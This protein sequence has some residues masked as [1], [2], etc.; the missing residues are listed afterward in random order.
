MSDINESASRNDQADHLSSDSE[1]TKDSS[2]SNS[3]SAAS[4]I[5]S[6]METDNASLPKGLA[7]FE[8]AKDQDCFYNAVLTYLPEESSMEVL[9]A[10]VASELKQI[11]AIYRPSIEIGNITWDDYL[12]NVEK[13]NEFAQEVELRVVAKIY[14]RP[15]VVIHPSPNKNRV[16]FE[17]SAEN[18]SENQAGIYADPL[19]VYYD[20]QNH[21]SGLYIEEGSG[22]SILDEL[23][24]KGEVDSRWLNA[25][26]IVPSTSQS[27]NNHDSNRDSQAY[28]SDKFVNKSPYFQDVDES[29]ANK[30][31]RVSTSDKRQAIS[32]LF[33]PEPV[34]PPRRHKLPSPPS[35]YKKNDTE[36]NSDDSDAN[37]N[38]EYDRSSA[39]T[40]SL[41]DLNTLDDGKADSSQAYSLT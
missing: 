35:K 19:F 31:R 23:T 16:I 27:Q 4:N 28:D 24:K 11:E 41:P 2:Y 17:S 36:L 29:S 9:R 20:D 8:I 10:R 14:K 22:K 1:I 5:A 21:Y 3:P 33:P 13:G 12:K 34:K 40:S 32:S 25:R 39:S 7:L 18:N 6:S 26:G 38:V 30:K 15:I 37:D